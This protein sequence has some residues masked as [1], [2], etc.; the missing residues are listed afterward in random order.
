MNK[1]TD[2]LKAIRQMMEKSSKFLSF[3]GLSIVFAGLF[4]TAGAI[5]AHLFLK[6]FFG[7]EYSPTQ[8]MMLYLA[9]AL[10]VLCLSVG[11]VTLFCRKKA[12]ASREPLFSSATRRAAYS[13]LLPLFAGG[14]FSLVLLFRGDIHIV[15]SATLL[16]YGIGVVNTS[17]YT[18]PELNCLGI[19]EV[20]LGLSSLFFTG[21]GLYFWTA[22]FGLC[23][24][25][26]GLIMYFRYEKNKTK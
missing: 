3:N 8:R 5:F 18:F 19:I 6:G 7:S 1:E 22:G 2:D 14:I 23:H 17:R 21:S 26:F 4:A 10:T 15:C 12:K 9:D 16:F 24:I 25:I 20:I 13:L 11:A